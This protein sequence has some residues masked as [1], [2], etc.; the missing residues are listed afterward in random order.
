MKLT[1]LFVK[2]DKKPAAK[3]VEFDNNLFYPKYGIISVSVF[4]FHGIAVYV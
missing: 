3:F 4:V 1:R 2:I